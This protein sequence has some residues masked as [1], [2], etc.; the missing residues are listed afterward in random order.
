MLIIGLGNEFRGD[1]AFGIQVILSLKRK[2]PLLGKFIIEQGDSSRLLD[3]WSGRHVVIVD[4]IASKV[5]PVGAM[6]VSKSRD[7]LIDNNQVLFSTHGLDLGHVLALGRDLK[8]FPKTVYFIG[9]VGSDWGMGDPMSQ[10]VEGAI[11]ETKK[12]IVA[13]VS[14]MQSNIKL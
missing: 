2:F 12:R 4:A 3:S 14:E 8:K 9:V 13:H 7:E 10:E 6:C 5:L 1:D 11:I